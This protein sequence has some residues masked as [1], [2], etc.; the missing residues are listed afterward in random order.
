VGKGAMKLR[1]TGVDGQVV[2]ETLD[3]WKDGETYKGTAQFK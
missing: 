3:K 1:I 2:E